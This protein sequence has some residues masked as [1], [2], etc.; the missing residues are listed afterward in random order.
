ML[1][2]RRQRKPLVIETTKRGSKA[3]GYDAGDAG[4]AGD[5]GREAGR[6]PAPRNLFEKD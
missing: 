3:H 2:V 1:A 5:V 6:C 4:D